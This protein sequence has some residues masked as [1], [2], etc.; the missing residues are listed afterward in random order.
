MLLSN[1]VYDNI[2]LGPHKLNS[3]K[4][5]KLL[6]CPD[7]R[8][9]ILYTHMSQT[10]RIPSVTGFASHSTKLTLGILKTL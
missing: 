5:A 3:N 9:I 10:Q 8:G 6:L 2:H 1:C 7:Q 4:T